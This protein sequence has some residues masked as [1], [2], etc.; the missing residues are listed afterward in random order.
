MAV[1]PVVLLLVGRSA[2]GQSIVADRTVSRVSDYVEQYYTRAQSI[3]TTESVTVQQIKRDLSFDGFARRL[4]YEL[5][6]EWDPSAAGDESPATV[7]R[8]LISV[9]GKPPKPGDKPECLD[10]KSISPEPLAFLLPDRRH[11]YSFVSAGLGR[12]D[13]QEAL[14]VDY[15]ALDVGKPK[16]E[17]TDECVSVD[18]PGKFRGRLWADPES[19]M[20]VRLDEQLTGMVDLPIPR[21]HQHLNGA[22]YITLERADTSIRYRP[23]TFADPHETLMLPAEIRSVSIWRN[24]GSVGNM[25]TQSFSNYRRFVTGGRIL[26]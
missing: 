3:V 7:T 8:E 22:L 11:R 12:V 23:V 6:V 18:V 25:V 14:M 20:V 5:R 17:W 15:R 4:V 9:N 1:V 19:A 26:R 10:P 24:A 16:V 13:G 2:I 21:K